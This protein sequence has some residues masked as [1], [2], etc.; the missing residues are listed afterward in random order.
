MEDFYI[1]PSNSYDDS[2]IKLTKIQQEYLLKLEN[3]FKSNLRDDYT[4]LC[5]MYKLFKSC[6]GTK[7]IEKSKLNCAIL[8]SK[9][10]IR[11]TEILSEKFGLS[12][13]TIYTYLKIAD[14]FID[15]LAGEKFKINEFYDLSIS[16]LQELL[17]LSLD[18]IKSAYKSKQLTFKSTKQDIRKFVKSFN[19]EKDNKVIDE[20]IDIETETPYNPDE[21]CLVTVTF[22]SDVLEFCRKQF[23]SKKITLDDYLI[24]LIREKMQV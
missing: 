20:E 1:T 16:K 6:K 5:I 13:K 17:P 23:I 18:T 2:N 11:L 7:G 24:S 14:R 19:A 3:I 4:L 9:N 22:P 15:F 12:E 8:G 10:K 21:N